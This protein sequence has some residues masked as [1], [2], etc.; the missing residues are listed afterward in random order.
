MTHKSI[1]DTDR[2]GKLLF[3][4]AVP[5]FF[6]MLVMAL[7]NVVDTIFIGRYIG[8][9]GIAGLSV[10]F[11]F[12]MLA[13]GFGMMAGIGGASLVSR[14][15]GAKDIAKAERTLGNAILIGSVFGIL[16]SIII[17]VN[18]DFW[19]GLAGASESILPYA[20]EY[21]EIVISFAILLTLVMTF[22]SVVVAAGNAKIPMVAMM[23][24]AGL[25]I[26]LDAVFIITFKMG[27]RGAAIATM[28]SN[29]ASLLI[30]L[31]YYF[32]GRSPL[33]I[34]PKI[35][36][37]DLRI[38][39][40]IVVIGVSGLAM[41]LSNSFSAI[42]LNNLLLIH[43]GDMAISTFGLIN[44]AM[45][46]IFMPCMVIGQGMQPII[47][48]NYGA[49]QYDRVFKALKISLIWATGIALAGF[50]VFY[51]FPGPIM[52]IFTT[53]PDLIAQTIYASKR[54]FLA[55]YLLGFISVASIVFQS[56]GKAIQ[57]FIASVAR[58]A[59]LFIPTLLLLSSLWHLD[60]IWYTFPA[61]DVLTALVIV[62]LLIPQIRDLRVRRDSERQNI[63]LP[64]DRDAALE[65]SSAQS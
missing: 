37:P 27:I 31:W 9:L 7:Y 16:M 49:R 44:R 40:Q 48:F 62:L 22:H 58:P 53:D 8:S 15:L 57:S 17:L 32:S 64:L 18:M 25:N 10:V 21:M 56:L 65:Q 20:R 63:G 39:G 36:I 55:I 5:A 13:Q 28:V 1:L 54:M 29:G 23:C 38:L 6:G 34:K 11:P 52:R 12:Q 24:G 45:V 4:L 51:F 30:F 2:I 35:F 33:K 14:T 41:T 61:T 47:G 26:I 43:G 42:F 60:G 50:F 46:F 59:L 3:K 19:L